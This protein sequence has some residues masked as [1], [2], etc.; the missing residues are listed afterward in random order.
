[1]T[2]SDYQVTFPF[3]ATTAPY[4]PA[5]PHRGDDYPCANGTP[6][7]IDGEEIARTGDTGDVTGPHLHVQE[8]LDDVANCRRPQHAFKPGLVTAANNNVNQQWGKHITILNPDGW[9]TTYCH[10]SEVFV[11][12]GQVIGVNMEKADVDNLVAP[13]Q[14]R[15]AD[16]QSYSGFVG[17]N[18]HDGWY[19]MV[20]SES[21]KD[22][23]GQIPK[24]QQQVDSLTAANLKLTEKLQSSDPDSVTVTKDGFW[25]ALLRFLG[26]G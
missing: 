7:V 22:Y 21:F 25:Q 16:E 9:N 3:G 14:G 26:K 8:W 4:T 6:L 17:K 15:P 13:M 23:V 12:V 18:F 20:A 5:H 2:A 1:M 19:D 10:L 11:N 24:L